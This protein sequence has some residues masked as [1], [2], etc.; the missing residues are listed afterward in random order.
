[1]NR[2]EPP[3]Q[4]SLLAWLRLSQM[5]PLKDLGF[6]YGPLLQWPEAFHS[7][8]GVLFTG[9]DLDIAASPEAAQ[10]GLP[11][12]FQKRGKIRTPK[13]HPRDTQGTP[14]G[15]QALSVLGT[16][17]GLWA[18]AAA[19]SQPPVSRWQ[20]RGFHFIHGNF[21]R[22]APSPRFFPRCATIPPQRNA[23]TSKRTM[24]LARYMRAA[25]LLLQLT[26]NS[27][28]AGDL[29]PLWGTCLGLQT[30]AV[31]QAGRNRGRDWRGESGALGWGCAKFGSPIPSHWAHWAIDFLLTPKP[32][33]KP[34][35]SKA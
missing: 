34:G 12:K 2:H 27:S 11:G 3:S 5:F 32:E 30:L 8:N 22:K 23:V 13:G 35:Q 25:S 4:G 15:G 31:A 20:N 10:P 26:V 24:R 19:F 7:V 21:T 33:S 28:Q 1:M 6:G 9:G 18:D 16:C 14:K 17:R 29:V